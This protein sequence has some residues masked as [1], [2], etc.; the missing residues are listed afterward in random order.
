MNDSRVR[1]YIH[2]S[3]CVCVPCVCHACVP[4]VCVLGFVCL[5]IDDVCTLRVFMYICCSFFYLLFYLADTG[6]KIN[7]PMELNKVYCIVLYCI[8]L[9]CVVLY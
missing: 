9:C 3:L 2:A 5:N 8:V 6:C 1:A 4:C 7:F